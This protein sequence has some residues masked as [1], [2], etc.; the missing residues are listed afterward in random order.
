MEAAAPAEVMHFRWFA[1]AAR[2]GKWCSQTEPYAGGR[3]AKTHPSSLSHI[4]Y[5]ARLLCS[6]SCVSQC[7]WMRRTLPRPGSR[8][9]SYQVLRLALLTLPRTRSP[10]GT[11]QVPLYFCE[12]WICVGRWHIRGE[13]HLKGPLPPKRIISIINICALGL[14]WKPYK[15]P[16]ICYMVAWSVPIGC[17]II[18]QNV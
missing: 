3:V 1:V 9:P 11:R 18:D 6:V 15:C 2:P 7:V 17:R 10:L 12:V 4:V 8:N 5:W 14:I 13:N 16:F